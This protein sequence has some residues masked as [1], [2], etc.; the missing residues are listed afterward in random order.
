MDLLLLLVVLLLLVLVV[1]VLVLVVLM[2]LLVRGGGRPGNQR[3][4]TRRSGT[5]P[6]GADYF[7]WPRC[8]AH[9]RLCRAG[10]R[11][12]GEIRSLKCG[13]P[14]TAKRNRRRQ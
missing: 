5:W 7:R 9:E 6:R 2:D 1:L 14:P 3:G 11:R 10:R 4:G 12:G 8:A 13:S